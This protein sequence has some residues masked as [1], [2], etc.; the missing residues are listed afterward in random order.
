MT[1]INSQL[2]SIFNEWEKLVPK[3]MFVRDGIM[4]TIP[5]ADKV[6]ST[7]KRRIAFMMKDKSD[8][9][10]DDARNWLI[11]N[12]D[13]NNQKNR[14]LGTKLF[15][16]IA[17]VLYGLKHDEC[18]Y[19]NVAN[20][21][22]L[23]DCLLKVPFA[24]IECKKEAGKGSL[25]DSVLQ[26]YLRGA[27]GTYL[28]QELSILQPNIYVCSGWPINDF[29]RNMYAPEELYIQSNNLAYHIPSKTLIILGYHP[30]ARTIYPPKNFAGVMNHYKDFL[31]TDYGKDFLASVSTQ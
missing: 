12:D 30:T 24:Y 28:H 25:D 6:W 26:Q 2:D 13:P 23:I 16:N 4:R 20:D 1:G 9:T 10:G 31:A 21:A 27:H 18:D 17:C 29:I 19:A 8:G 3:D 15:R 7:S 5:N 14:R 11:D 22:L